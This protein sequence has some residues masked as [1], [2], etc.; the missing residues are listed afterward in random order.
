M[1]STVTLTPEAEHLLA[2]RMRE[3]GIGF[4]QAVNEAIIAGLTS[5]EHQSA[6]SF[7]TPTF[8]LGSP[9]VPVERALTLYGDLEDEEL[10]RKRSLGK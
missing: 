4:K 1:R 3:R 5:H 9:R 10:L 7:E 6:E 2:A 8:P